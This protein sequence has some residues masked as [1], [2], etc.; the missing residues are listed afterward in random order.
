M[1]RHHFSFLELVLV[2]SGSA[3]MTLMMAAVA[4][5][6]K[7]DPK[8]I[9]CSKVMNGIEQK[10]TAF[11]NDNGGTL[12]SGTNKGKLWAEQLVAGGYFEK[13]GYYD[14]GRTQPKNFECPAETRDRSVGSR[15][16]LHPT[17]AIAT[18]YDYGL[19]WL[20]HR[21]ITDDTQKNPVR[22]NLKKPAE[23]IRMLEGTKF[24]LHPTPSDVTE[25]HGDGAGNVLFE[26]GHIAFMDPI[27]YRDTNV[28]KREFWYE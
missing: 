9:E 23:L 5:H 2:L 15:K 13:D 22:K 26:D 1:R 19:N 16:Y 18:S 25:R 8:T 7:D 3:L 14:K 17:M 20:T 6:M 28:Y 11:E 10:L 4:V 24:A 21:K 12:I 27:P